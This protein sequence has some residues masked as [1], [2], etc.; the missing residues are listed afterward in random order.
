[1]AIKQK[2]DSIHA[3]VSPYIKKQAE[4]L[5]ETEEFSSMSD[6]VSIALAEFIGKYTRD[7]KEKEQECE[8]N[9][10]APS[11]SDASYLQSKEGKALIKSVIME[12]LT[13]TD[14][15]YMKES[16]KNGNRPII[17]DD[18]IIE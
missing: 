8:G 18:E 17:V 12:A 2:K 10:S 14:A 9:V 13:P 6:L 11:S 3:T 15:A 16:K 7:Q 1:M 5:V 4:A